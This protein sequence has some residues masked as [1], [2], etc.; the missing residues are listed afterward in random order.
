MDQKKVSNSFI[1]L[2]CPH[3]Q[4]TARDKCPFSTCLRSRE[5]EEDSLHLTWDHSLH[6]LCSQGPQAQLRLSPCHKPR[7]HKTKE[8]RPKFWV[9]VIHTFSSSTRI[10]EPEKIQRETGTIIRRAGKIRKERKSEENEKIQRKGLQKIGSR[11]E[12]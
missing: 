6:L 7:G 11:M 5:P 4:H 10:P 8:A 9:K 12:I 1:L 3:N 2:R